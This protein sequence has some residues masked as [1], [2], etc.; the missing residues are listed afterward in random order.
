MNGF[1]F[2]GSRH[3]EFNEYFCHYFVIGKHTWIL[4]F[5]QSLYPCTSST[6]RNFV[7][8][9]GI[10]LWNVSLLEFQ[11]YEWASV[12]SSVFKFSLCLSSWSSN[13]NS[14]SSK[15]QRKWGRT[16]LR[17]ILMT[18]IPEGKEALVSSPFNAPLLSLQLR[19]T[20][21]LLKPSS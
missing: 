2:V 18:C 4:Q 1:Y 6:F 5:F 3:F 16:V 10:L 12:L 13:A 11:N 9:S 21:M 20:N 14:N 7:S 19:I 17:S 15:V 8:I